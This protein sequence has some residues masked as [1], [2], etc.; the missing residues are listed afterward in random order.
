MHIIIRK[1]IQYWRFIICTIY[2]DLLPLPE[3]AEVAAAADGVFPILFGG[4]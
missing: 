1:D 4:P 3:K 2:R